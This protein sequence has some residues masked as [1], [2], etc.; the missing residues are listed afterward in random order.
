MRP[1]DVKSITHI[2]GK[3][4][5]AISLK[6]WMKKLVELVILT[7]IGPRA[8]DRPIN[9]ITPGRIC[10]EKFFR[11]IAQKKM[12]PLIGGVSLYNYS[13]WCILVFRWGV[14]NT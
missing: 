10:Q 11:Q 13:N 8:R 2:T 6:K 9:Y 7:N 5:L 3:V 1:L 12:I 14:E 4:N